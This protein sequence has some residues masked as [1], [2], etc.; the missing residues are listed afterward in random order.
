MVKIL[1]TTI[2][3]NLVPLIFSSRTCVYNI[4][5]FIMVV[6]MCNVI[7]MHLHAFI[8]FHQNEVQPI[9]CATINGQQNIIHTL[10]EKFGVD[11]QEETAVRM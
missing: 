3:V 11:P 8:M 1:I 2:Q 9:H 7:C 6:L 5:Y 4:L 10:V